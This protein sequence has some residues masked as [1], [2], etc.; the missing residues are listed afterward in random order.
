MTIKMPSLSRRQIIKLISAAA[1]PFPAVG[2]CRG[3]APGLRLVQGRSSPPPNDNSITLGLANPTYYMGFSPFLNWWK[4]AQRAGH[5]T[6]RRRNLSGKALWDAGMYLSGATG[7][8][9]TPALLTS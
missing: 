4:T 6:S 5:H 8:I 1:I 9:V 2:L 3:A 7:E